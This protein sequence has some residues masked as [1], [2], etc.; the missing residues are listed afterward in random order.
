MRA[1]AA[2]LP[3]SLPCCRSALP[4]PARV[5]TRLDAAR[6]RPP[7]RHPRH[8]SRRAI[9][10]PSP[11]HAT[12]LPSQS[13]TPR[14][15]RVLACPHCA[16]LECQHSA[17]TTTRQAAAHASAPPLTPP[18]PSSPLQPSSPHFASPPRVPAPP[19]SAPPQTELALR[20]P[21]PGTPPPTPWPP[22]LRRPPRNPFLRSPSTRATP[23]NESL[24]AL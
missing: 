11:G 18:L 4:R 2:P 8:Q 3:R 12:L 19:L 14:R 21:R 7:A 16:M 20:S 1:L 17:T 6:C 24:S 13:L 9:T 22:L 5:R 15:A 10:A 23:G